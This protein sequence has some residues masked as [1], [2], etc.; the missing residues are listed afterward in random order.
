[1]PYDIGTNACLQIQFEGRHA[2]QQVMNVMTYVYQ[3]EAI[4]EDG[5][6]LI[7]E[8]DGIVTGGGGLW[9]NWLAC[10]SE[11][12]TDC[13]RFYQ[14]IHP[15][16]YAYVAKGTAIPEAGQVAS[17]AM[18]PNIS[19][20]V[21]RQTNFAGREEVSTLKLP[22]VPS[23]RVVGGFLTAP[24]VF[25]LGE[26]GVSSCNEINLGSGGKMVPIPW[27]RT[28]PGSANQLRTAYAHNTVRTMHRRT[29]GL[30]T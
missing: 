3:N 1:M 19:Q 25:A 6:L 21:T 13:V 23:D 29:V 9:Q 14:W 7:D 11:D 12:V 26:F 27:N 15:I 4:E 22:G 28:S 17:P 10:L 20:V 24:A 5:P 16:R 8:I 30:G 18:P 2:G